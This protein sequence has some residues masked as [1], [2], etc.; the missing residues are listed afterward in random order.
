MRRNHSPA[1]KAKVALAGIAGETTLADLALR[2]RRPPR[3]DHGLKK[4][5]ILFDAPQSVR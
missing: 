1:F 3:P 2:F 5:Q 4:R